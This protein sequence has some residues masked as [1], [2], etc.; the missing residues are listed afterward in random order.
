MAVP[1]DSTR[2]LAAPWQSDLAALA[3][4]DPRQPAAQPRADRDDRVARR[5]VAATRRGVAR[6][7]A[8]ARDVH[9]ANTARGIHRARASAQG[10]LA[11]GARAGRCL[12]YTS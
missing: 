8:R 3:L 2:Q 7:V 6:A 9:P 1:L 11:R 10:G 5:R 4:E 12:L